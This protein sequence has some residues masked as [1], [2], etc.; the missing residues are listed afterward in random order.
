MNRHAYPIAFV[1]CLSILAACG[2][3]RA[4]PARVAPAPAAGSVALTLEVRGGAE[5]V[6]AGLRARLERLSAEGLLPL[7][8]IEVTVAGPERVSARVG[9]LPGGAC[10]EA[11]LGDAVRSLERWATRSG[12]LTL[13]RT[14][15]GVAARVLAQVLE[16]PGVTAREDGLGAVVVE[17]MGF[18]QVAERLAGLRVPSGVR[19]M[20]EGRP[21]REGTDEAVALWA[22]DEAP[23]VGGR[24]VAGAKVVTDA[25]WGPE[26]EVTFTP[27]GGERFAA[28][29]ERAVGQVVVMAFEGRV[30][31]A[32]RVMERIG[33]GRAKIT[34]GADGQAEALRQAREVAALLTA[35]PLGGEVEVVGREAKCRE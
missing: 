2:R 32:P 6:A 29:T 4:E 33:G 8:A 35:G 19:V 24:D 14:T 7:G 25:D 31:M 1:L 9:V 16:W 27:A 5:A 34:M 17:G 18:A 26:I 22:V 11:A 10:D 20:A 3:E 12:L 28:M 13:H 15:A 30:V 21:A 23:E